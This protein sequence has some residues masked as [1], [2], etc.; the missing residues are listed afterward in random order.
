M[1]KKVTACLIAFTC[2]FS[3]AYSFS[4]SGLVDNKT[5]ISA[6]NFSN[7]TLTQSNAL[8]LSMNVPLAND[9]YIV[10]E[11][12]FKYQF[13]AVSGR[14]VFTPI[15]D[16]NLL[17]FAGNYVVEDGTFSYL[18]GRFNVNDSSG[19]YFT[20]SSDGVYISYDSLKSKFGFYAG[21][22]GLLNSLNVKMSDANPNVNN[23][24]FYNLCAGYIPVSAEFFYKKLF[25]SNTIGFQASYFYNTHKNTDNGMTD[26]LYGTLSL[27]G[28]VTTIGM[29]D[30]KGVVESAGFR[31]VSLDSKIDLSFFLGALG[32]A[33]CGIEYISGK[34]SESFV[35]FT[36]ITVRS[37]NNGAVASGLFPKVN[38]A[39]VY[40][41]IYAS[42][43]EKVVFAMPEKQMS[44]RG[45][46]TTIN[47]IFNIFSDLQVGCDITA[48]IDIKE[49]ASSN[50]Y[51]LLKASLAF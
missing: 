2:L 18:I 30:F 38:C 51:A 21:Y 29:Y 15:V 28:P 9:F 43:T 36:S 23:D 3:A 1:K 14:S 44:L 20:Q 35:P 39:I 27:S 10:A 4:W 5:K 33:G 24:K 22:T 32:V 13:T 42:L 50:Y 46:D 31:T 48:Y 11:S 41:N 12:L 16:L 17:K 25:G 49:A 40:N 47:F 6:Q 7:H 26:K 19:T 37:V 34:L 8:Y 45:F